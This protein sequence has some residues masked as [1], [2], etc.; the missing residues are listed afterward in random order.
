MFKDTTGYTNDDL[1]ES[2]TFVTDCAATAPKVF[3]ASDS[4]DCAAHSHSY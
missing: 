3:G 4:T 1:E 2:F